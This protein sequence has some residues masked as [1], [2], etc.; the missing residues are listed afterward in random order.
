MRVEESLELEISQMNGLTRDE[1]LSLSKRDFMRL[2]R[3][4]RLQ[5]ELEAENKK[6]P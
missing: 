6:A 4:K 2:I 1:L 5:N 3:F